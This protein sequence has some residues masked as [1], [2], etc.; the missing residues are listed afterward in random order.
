[1]ALSP[2]LL[3]ISTHLTEILDSYWS[4]A[5]RY[6]PVYPRDRHDF[7]PNH[8][9][10]VGRSEHHKNYCIP[11][12]PELDV[13]IQGGNNTVIPPL[14]NDIKLWTNRNAGLMC[15]NSFISQ[16]TVQYRGLF[17]LG[18]MN[19]DL[20]CASEQYISCVLGQIIPYIVQ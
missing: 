11:I 15:A 20:G 6:I 19:I 9:N 7:Q 4:R 13:I 3:Y 12:G 14:D 8:A 10:H 16:S 18:H 1:M 5:G 17:V 2:S